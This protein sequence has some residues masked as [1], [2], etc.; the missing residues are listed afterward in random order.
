MH[1]SF[2]NLKALKLAPSDRTFNTVTHHSLSM[3][4]KRQMNW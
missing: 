3:Y 2:N 1:C 4:F